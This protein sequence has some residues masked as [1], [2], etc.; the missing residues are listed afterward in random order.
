MMD[1]TPRGKAT[2]GFCQGNR[3][4]LSGVEEA[5]EEVVIP[6]GSFAPAAH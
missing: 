2:T 4:K 6:S 5:C 1:R 3:V